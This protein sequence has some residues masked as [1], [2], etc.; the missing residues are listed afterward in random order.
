M[1]RNGIGAE[2]CCL[3]TGVVHRW[4]CR[5][6]AGYPSLTAKFAAVNGLELPLAYLNFGGYAET[7]RMIRYTRLDDISSLINILTPN[8]LP[9]DESTHYRNATRLQ[10]VLDAQQ[11]RLARI[12]TQAQLMPRQRYAMDAYYDARAN[13]QGLEDFAARIPLQDDLQ[14]GVQVNPEITSNLFPKTQNTTMAL[15]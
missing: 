6:S 4:S 10:R 2:T 14:S 7:A 12:R 1:G 8:V 15:K 9:W 11:G 3:S 13:S 5:K